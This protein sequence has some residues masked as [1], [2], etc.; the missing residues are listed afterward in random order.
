MTTSGIFLE[1][2]AAQRAGRLADAEQACLQ[3][4]RQDP[5][6]ADALHLLGGLCHQRGNLPAAEAWIRQALRVREDATM[7]GNMGNLQSE[8]NRAQDAQE[9][10]R[11]AVVLD[12]AHANTYFN[13][14]NL[15]QRLQRVREAELTL[16]RALQITPEF[17]EANLHLGVMLQNK[18]HYGGAEFCYRQALITRPDFVEALVNLAEVL[19][20][21]HRLTV[22]EFQLKKALTI[23]PSFAKALNNLG[24]LYS[25]E[26]RRDEARTCYLRVLSIE[27]YHEN[28]YLNLA[29]LHQELQRYPQAQ[30]YFD[31]ALALDAVNPKV[32]FNYGLFLL[33]QGEYA[34]GWP[35]Y[36]ARWKTADAEAMP[37][38]V[39]PRWLGNDDIRGKT[40]LLHA[41]QGLGDTLQF[42]RYA[43]VLHARGA[44]VLM[45]VP[46]FLKGLLAGCKGVVEVYATGEILPPFDY[47]SPLM[48][49]PLLCGT[50]I[51]TIPSEIP[52][53]FAR[54]D[55]IARWG[56]KLGKHSALRVGLV[57]AGAARREQAA[58]YVVDR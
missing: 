32:R 8:M 44:R 10:Y 41:E 39:Q 14:S 9:C 1:A 52:Y 25:E 19:K 2:L 42:V 16:L 50:T 31:Q 51:D 56:H 53:L 28:I 37:N 18:R 26:A 6:H 15:L 45:Q 55:A 27:T 4:I 38:F 34:R 22:A 30:H 20:L 21:T 24:V 57:W 40:I 33:L 5:R 23:A 48:S 29:H 46:S 3:I 11:R 35:L 54:E 7:L 17:A 43:D 47:F 58:A 49:L 12:P 13:Y 36:E